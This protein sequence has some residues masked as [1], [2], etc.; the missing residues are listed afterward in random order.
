MLVDRWGRP[1]T[2]LRISVTNAC[3]YNCFFCHREGHKVE[4]GEMTPQEIGRLVRILSGQGIRT[5]KLTGG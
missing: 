5:V 3:N 4:G 1:V 2:D